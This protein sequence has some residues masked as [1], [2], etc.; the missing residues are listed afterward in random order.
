L[1]KPNQVLSKIYQIYSNFI[2]SNLPKFA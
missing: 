1:P 2:L